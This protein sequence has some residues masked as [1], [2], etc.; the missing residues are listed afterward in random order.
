MSY[1][2]GLD[3]GTTNCKAVLC[4]LPSASPIHV[5]KIASP[6]RITSEGSDY[7]VHDLMQGVMRLLKQCVDYLGPKKSEDIEFV[8]LCSV[9]ESGVLVRK[10]GTYS[11][12]SICWYDPRGASYVK[13]LKN[14]HKEAWLYNITGIPAHSNSALFKILWMRDHGESLAG[15]TWLPLADF[16]AWQLSGV[17]GIDRT[18]ASRTAVLDIRSARISSEVT[19]YFEVPEHLFPELFLS[20]MTR[21]EICKQVREEIGLPKH[22]SVHVAGHDHMVGSIGCRFAETQEVLNSTGTSEG[23]LVVQAT[24]TLGK[25]GLNCQL[26]NGLYVTEPLFSLYASLPTAGYCFDWMAQQLNTTVD[27]LI[28]ETST[29]LVESYLKGA[30]LSNV[31]VFLPR[32]R[33]SGPPQRYVDASAVLYGLRDATKSADLIMAVYMGVCMELWSLATSMRLPE[34]KSIKVIG[35]A[36]KNPLW[37]QMKADLFGRAMRA[38]EVVEAP[39]C[40]AVILAGKRLGIAVKPQVNETSYEPNSSRTSELRE[41]YSRRYQRLSSAICELEMSWRTIGEKKAALRPSAQTELPAFMVS[42]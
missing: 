21:G 33:G 16:V 10:D 36:T 17:L 32:L 3:L 20:G 37:M 5:E 31:P 28:K 39:A 7:V 24:P 4:Q 2:I 35:P 11:K 8:S 41:L 40:G 9:G 29:K 19:Q 22:C 34:D 13:Q 12:T 18:L 25:Q 38:C 42:R 15:A 30:H 1:A 23:F 27:K 26:T 14:A 6:K